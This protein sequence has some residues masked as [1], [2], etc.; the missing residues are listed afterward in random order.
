MTTTTTGTMGGCKWE[1]TRTDDG[2][3]ILYDSYGNDTYEFTEEAWWYLQDHYRMAQADDKLTEEEFVVMI[4]RS[5]IV[6]QLLK[7][8]YINGYHHQRFYIERR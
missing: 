3:R 2:D 7:R 8:V 6:F 5:C 1:I 4:S